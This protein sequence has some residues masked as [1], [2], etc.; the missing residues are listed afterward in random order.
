MIN[1]KRLLRGQIGLLQHVETVHN[2]TPPPAATVSQQPPPPATTVTQQPP[3]PSLDIESSDFL[4]SAHCVTQS[5]TV[6]QSKKPKTSKSRPYNFDEP[7]V[8]TCKP[9]MYSGTPPPTAVAITEPQPPAATRSFVTNITTVVT[10][11]QEQPSLVTIPPLRQGESKNNTLLPPQFKEVMGKGDW[12]WV[13]KCLYDHQGKL[14]TTFPQNWHYPP[15]VH[16]SGPP[17]PANFFRRRLFVW[18]PMRMWGFKL[19]CPSCEK[20]LTHGGLYRKCREV[21][22]IDS[23]YYLVGE[24]SRCRPCS[25]SLTPWSSEVLDQLDPAH[26]N[27][28]PA[29]LTSYLALDKKCVTLMKQR[30]LGNSS[31]NI[32]CSLDEIHSEEWGKRVMQY[33][34]ACE[35]HRRKAGLGIPATAYE[36][37]PAFQPLPTAAWYETAHVFE[38]TRHINEMKAI[39]T[40]TY[41][42]ILKLDSTKK[43]CIKS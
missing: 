15:E 37:P 36:P 12:E 11:P 30:T 35:L 8:V 42:R 34:T 17:D 39:I 18:A 16:T 40:S 4:P 13:S 33:L 2:R 9:S 10:Q 32:K 22:D 28:F 6:K 38:V 26:R 31:T 23:K 41:G 20:P 27:M 1:A 3:L 5:L 21:I 29:V 14:R 24:Y 7:S 25:K 43:V 19:K